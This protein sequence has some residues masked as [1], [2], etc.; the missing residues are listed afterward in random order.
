[1]K[2]TKW[3]LLTTLDPCRLSC[4]FWK[5]NQSINQY[6]LLLTPDIVLKIHKVSNEIL[7]KL[8]TWM[9]LLLKFSLSWLLF[10]H[11]LSASRQLPGTCTM[12]PDSVGMK[13]PHWIWSRHWWLWW[14][15]WWLSSR[16]LSVAWPIRFSKS[17]W[18]LS[19]TWSRYGRTRVNKGRL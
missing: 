7:P 10:I 1:M 6:Y 2:K 19:L 18:E 8:A 17:L 5:G 14:W 13:R 4:I 3:A 9:S 15:H 16:S 11:P 12:S